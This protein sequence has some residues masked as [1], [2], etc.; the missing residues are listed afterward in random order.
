M[1]IGTVKVLLLARV[2]VAVLISALFLVSCS[3]YTVFEELPDNPQFA[4]VEMKTEKPRPLSEGSLFLSHSGMNLYED[5]R[6][7]RVGDIITVTLNERT[8]SSKSSETSVSKGN[9]NAADVVSVLGGTSR[10]LPAD[11][12]SSRSFDG[13]GEA[14]QENSLTGNIAVTISD[15]LGNGLL[16]IRGEKWMTLT[17]GK[18]YIRLSGLIRP[19]DI[20]STNSISSTKIADAR[21]AY[22]GTGELQEATRQGWASRFF[23]SQLWPF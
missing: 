19:E 21:I 15:A 8:V 13:T 11:F 9:S 16:R 12:N 5:R 23:N 2:S 14:D 3:T 7:Y 18:E 20:S 10:I 6:A 17:T 1:F 4:P 22:S